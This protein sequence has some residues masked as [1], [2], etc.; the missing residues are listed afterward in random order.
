MSD[1]VPTEAEPTDIE[2]AILGAGAMGSIVGAH[3]ARA[4]HKVVMLARGQ[5]AMAL[6]ADGLRIRGLV[7]LDV[8]VQVIEEPAHLR[9]ARVFIVTTKAIGTATAL[10][11]YRHA[12]IDSAFSI[13]NGVM[14]DE[15]LAAAFG[16]P[17]VLGALANISGEL[18]PDGAVL[19]TRNVNVAVGELAG[20]L[21]DRARNISRALLDAGVR[22]KPVANV[23]SQEWSK[24]AGWVGLVGVAITARTYT[25]KYLL[26]P[27]GATVLVRLVREVNQL[28]TA[29]NISLNDDSMFPVATL[30][31]G[32]EAAAV[33]IVQSFGRQFRDNSPEHKLST[34]QDVEAGRPLEVEETLGFAVR[35]ARDLGLVLPLLEATCYLAGTI[36]RSRSP[37]G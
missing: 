18:L 32:P 12:K 4:G 28:A 1:V 13:Q 27:G 8:P 17:A 34:L 5:R 2:F 7:E 35:R 10:A 29:Q 21:S 24:F 31:A 6:R 30:S 26:D 36:D 11:A 16:K 33:E 19:F 23:Q 22:S 3:L 15:L 25:W 20:G 9:S 37:K 14:K